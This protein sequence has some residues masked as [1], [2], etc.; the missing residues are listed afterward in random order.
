MRSLQF[1][2]QDVRERMQERDSLRARLERS[3]SKLAQRQERLAVL[4]KLLEAEREDVE[5]LEGLSL[6]AIF[7]TLLASKEQQLEKERQEVLAASLKHGE[8]LAAVQRLEQGIVVL[9]NSLAKLDGVDEEY[10]A[11]LQRKESL[12][13]EQDGAAAQELAAI[14]E[15][16][17][18]A[19]SQ[20]REV[21]EACDTGELTFETLE[22]LV[23]RLQG[24]QGWGTWDVLGGGLIAT[25]LKHGEID[26]A[27]KLIPEAQADLFEFASQLEDV[28]LDVD[29]T[30][31]LP[32]FHKFADYLFDGLIVDWIV[33]SK[34]DLS[35]ESAVKI[36][37]KVH[38]ILNWLNL[39]RTA[40]DEQIQSLE[41]RRSELIQRA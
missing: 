9:R 6:R 41:T 23:A 17:A 5:R 36:Q 19:R 10:K 15:E 28:D 33:Q 21:R 38:K 8:C 40:L 11:I 24:A 27:C 39:R 29:L 20:G 7:H 13:L 35:L 2:L 22:Q 14:T 31:D 16:I 34:I 37:R 25:S 26:E 32:G 3:S 18:I 12:L 1:E 30:L 4:A